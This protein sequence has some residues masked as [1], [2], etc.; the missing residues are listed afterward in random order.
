M[1]GFGVKA[2]LGKNNVPTRP[3]N[4]GAITWNGEGCKRYVVFEQELCYPRYL[5]EF[6]EV[7][8]LSEV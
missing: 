3:R 7:R 8:A 1:R 6:D 5:L 4:S 2:V